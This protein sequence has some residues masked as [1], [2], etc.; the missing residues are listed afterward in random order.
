VGQGSELKS[1]Q[2]YCSRNTPYFGLVLG[3]NINGPCVGYRHNVM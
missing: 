3:F 2:L 1:K